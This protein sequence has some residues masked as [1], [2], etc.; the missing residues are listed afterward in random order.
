MEL[1]KEIKQ[2]ITERCLK[3]IGKDILFY[4]KDIFVDL[5]SG[6]H[7]IDITNCGK[8]TIAEIKYYRDGYTH[9]FI[10]VSAKNPKDINNKYIGI[11]IAVE[12][13]L[14]KLITDFILKVENSK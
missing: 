8:F 14:D 3:R 9:H 5:L 11:K 2:K 12:D 13:A 1:N 4:I 6:K 7:S 10:G